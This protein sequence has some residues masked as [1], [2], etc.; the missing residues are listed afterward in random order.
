VPGFDMPI[1]VTLDWPTWSLIKPTET[2]QT[3]TGR[4]G[5]ATDFRVDDNFYVVQSWSTDGPNK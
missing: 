5:N 4:L 2:W 3:P 1:R